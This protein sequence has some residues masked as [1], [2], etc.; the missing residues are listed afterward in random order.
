MSLFSALQISL[1]YRNEIQIRTAPHRI[2]IKKSMTWP[3]KILIASIEFKIFV[4]SEASTYFMWALYALN[5]CVHF[6]LLHYF[7]S[8]SRDIYYLYACYFGNCQGGTGYLGSAEQGKRAKIFYRKGHFWAQNRAIKTIPFQK[9][10]LTPKTGFKRAK[11]LS[12]PTLLKDLFHCQRH[13]Y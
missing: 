9:G 3:R 11:G 12:G 4:F 2:W 13:L 8:Y 1:L 10:F 6:D 7:F 5:C